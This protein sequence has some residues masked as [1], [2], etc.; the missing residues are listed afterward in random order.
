MNWIALKRKE[1]ACLRYLRQKVGALRF[2]KLSVV[3]LLLT[4]GC[5]TGSSVEYSGSN[6][7]WYGNRNQCI[8]Y[9]E[10]FEEES[11]WVVLDEELWQELRQ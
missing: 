11:K 7:F 9:L 2:L 5:A 4:S 10:T 3:L 6:A 1:V 8:E